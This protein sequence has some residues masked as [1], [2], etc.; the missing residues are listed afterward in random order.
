M[1][2]LEWEEREKG[3]GNIFENIMPEIFQ[4]CWKKNGLCIHKTQW[5]LSKARHKGYPC[6]DTLQ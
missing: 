1:E 3:S 6:V 2:V 5:L 4:I